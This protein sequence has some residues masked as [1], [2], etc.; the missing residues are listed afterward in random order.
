[1]TQWHNRTCFVGEGDE[2]EI[3]T[4]PYITRLLA[5]IRQLDIERQNATQELENIL[6]VVNSDYLAYRTA[7]ENVSDKLKEQAKQSQPRPTVPSGDSYLDDNPFGLPP[8]ERDEAGVYPDLDPN[9]EG[10]QII[11]KDGHVISITQ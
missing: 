10:T 1:M 6:N 5:R 3:V 8:T 11:D 7:L 9:T 2:R 4:D